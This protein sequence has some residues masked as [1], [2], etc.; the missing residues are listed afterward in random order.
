MNIIRYLKRNGFRYALNVFYQ[1]KIQK[2]LDLIVIRFTKFKKLQ[3]IIVIE[4]HTDFDNNGGAFY[5]YLIRNNYNKKY[6]IILLLKNRLV[7]TLPENVDYFYLKKPS[8]RKAYL[9]SL[10]KFF[11]FDNDILEKYRD[12]QIFFYLTHGG[13]SLKNT[14]GKIYVPD[15][16]DYV[17][18]PSNSVDDILMK[19]YGMKTKDR[20]LHIGFPCQDVLYSEKH[21]HEFL[22]NFNKSIVWAPTF[23]KG[24]GHNR[25]DS[26]NDL[27]L[28]IPL[29]ETVDDLI[30]LNRYL[31]SRNIGLV[32][33]LHPM[34]DLSGVELIQLSHV[35]FLTNKEL[36]DKN[37]DIYKLLVISDALISDYSAIS[38]DYLHLNK[39]LAY[40]FSDL[41]DYKLGL[42]V[43]DVEQ[44]IAGDKILALS[45]L[46]SFIDSVS[47]NFDNN[48]RERQ[49]L[50]D[51]IFEKQ[52][53]GSCE[54][55]AKFMGL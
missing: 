49:Q 7:R 5:D 19:Q 52:D 12:D 30:K 8:L 27:P 32:I 25:N 24:G 21:D 38:F 42:S 22:S 44:F 18:S 29:V 40:V 2:I 43:D 51:R 1:Y 36:S 4:C 45:D 31:S 39:P 16:V 48:Q 11:L 15:H 9:L 17:L 33:K 47:N 10:S 26:L 41:K 35:I 28:G 50:F 20:F 54:R 6:K 3:N 13:F 37:I 53:G 14:A 23:R 55:L 34:Q 46:Y